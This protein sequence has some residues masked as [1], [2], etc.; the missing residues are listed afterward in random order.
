M[1]REYWMWNVRLDKNYT[2]Q[3]R[4]LTTTDKIEEAM[5]Y[6]L[7]YAQK[8]SEVEGTVLEVTTLEC[9]GSVLVPDGVLDLTEEGQ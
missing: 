3:C 4:L 1:M 6:A 5:S 2:F 7:A 9:E 8:T